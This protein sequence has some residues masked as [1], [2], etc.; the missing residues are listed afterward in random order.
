ML[1]LLSCGDE[2]QPAVAAA[3]EVRFELH[4]GVPAFLEVPFPSDLYLQPDGTIVDTLVGLDTFIPSASQTI[5]TA[6]G[7]LRG[8]GR[9]SGVMFRID[10]PDETDPTAGGPAPAIVDQSS[11]PATPEDCQLASASVMLVD[12][13][14]PAGSALL[15]CRAGYFDNRPNG[16]S[17]P[18]VLVVLP[19]RGTVLAEG[20]RYAAV[21]T[22]SLTADGGRA[23]RAG[24]TFASVRDGER[25]TKASEQLY[26][27][28]V[29]AVLEKVPSLEVSRV[30]GVSPFTTQRTTSELFELRERIGDLAPPVVR[31]DE[32]SVQPMYPGFFSR[33]PSPDATATLD[34][35]LGSPGK[36]ADGGDDPA[37]DQANG[38]G[39]DAILAIATGVFEAPNFLRE[40]PEGY[41]DS[42]HRTFARD[43]AGVVIAD[44]EHPTSKI[45]LTIAVPDAPMPADGYPIVV[46][47]HGLQGD[48][49]FLLTLANVYAQEGWATVAIEAV[50]FGARSAQ[51]S[52]H[53]DNISRHAWSATTGHY[54]GPDGFVDVNANPLDL[55]GGM[56]SFGATRDQFRQSV[57]DIGTLAELLRDPAIDLGPLATLHPGL[58][59]DGERLAYVGDSFGAVLGTVVA[60]VDPRYR[61]MVLNVGGGGILVELVSN[62]PLLASVI[63]TLGGLTFGLTHDRLDWQSPLVSLLQP[64]LDAADPLSY[65]DYLVRDALLV[66]PTGSPKSIVYVEVLWD[67]LMANEGTEALAHAAGIPLAAPSVGPLS[68]VQLADA[69]PKGGVIRGVPTSGHTVVM[70]QAGPATHGSNLYGARGLKKYAVPFSRDDNNQF[71]ELAEPIEVAQPYLGLQAMTVGFIRTAFDGE[72]PAVGAFPQPALDF[73]GD[74]LLD[75]D[76]PEPLDP[77][78]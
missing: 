16:S 67:E 59:L 76:D 77:H 31:W 11:L 57:L 70:V 8:F 46:L 20:H 52:F 4:E 47:Q 63:G 2:A 71:A 26:G 66:E 19:A 21:L 45:W 65:A 27:A 75:E 42:A 60:A 5:M 29:D 39:H 18:P 28:A 74:G 38:A 10:R 53:T 72:V 69:A 56:V 73:D 36:L 13:E 3:P 61:A 40:R 44:A 49:S 41:A 9:S 1:G 58:K 62:A 32:S 23:L 30:V 64:I 43:E 17:V 68:D 54:A 24:T 14:A 34:E 51:G 15:G 78:Q 25:R 33:D 37:F 48:R 50:T 22:T 55:F 12:L 35:W 7:E 6:L